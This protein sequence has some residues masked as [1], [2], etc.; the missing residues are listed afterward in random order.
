MNN[1]EYIRNMTDSELADYIYSIYLAGRLSY[2]YEI[3][4]VSYETKNLI[5]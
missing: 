3:E 4:S 5:N 2:K 1:A